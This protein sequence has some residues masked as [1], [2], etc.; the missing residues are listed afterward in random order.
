MFNGKGR[1]NQCHGGPEFSNVAVGSLSDRAF[2]NTGV[3]PDAEDG[4]QKP[5]SLSKFSSKTVRNAE[6][7]GPYF[8]NGGTLTLRQVVDFYDRGGNFASPN[9]DS[10]VRPLGL[11]E[12]EKNALVSFMLA[13]TDDRVRCEKAPFD[14]PSINVPNGPNV[15]AVGAGGR[16]SNQC[17][18]PYLNVNHF[19]P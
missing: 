12:T 2:T 16:P 17:I 7:T 14:H 9:R 3:R 10:Q 15:T 8:H 5:A 4:G 13:L 1:C 18:K 11:T 19:N 6:L